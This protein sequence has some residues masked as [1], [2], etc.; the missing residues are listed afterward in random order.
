[1]KALTLTQ[2]WAG[3]VASGIK[4]VENRPRKMI[5]REDFGR[6]FAIH[7]SR[8]LDESVYDRIEDIAPELGLLPKYFS[9]LSM[10]DVT[11]PEWYKLSRIKSAIIGVAK[12]G[13]IIETKGSAKRVQRWSKFV[14]LDP[15]QHRWY[16]GPVGYALDEVVA[17]PTARSASARS[18]RSRSARSASK[19][20]RRPR[21][22][23]S[24]KRIKSAKNARWASALHF[25]SS[26]IIRPEG[27]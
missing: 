2:P 17:L 3:L 23:S 13:G 6:W 10:A 11:A 9:S 18:A 12:L 26:L 14:D 25:L 7:A 4:L 20:G 15:A 8:E 19:R 21:S 5:K 22:A 16:F 24:A 1:M 27:K